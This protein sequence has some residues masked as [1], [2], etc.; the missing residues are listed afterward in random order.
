MHVAPGPGA[1]QEGAR[2][3]LGVSAREWVEVVKVG[4]RWGGLVASV[5]TGAFLPQPRP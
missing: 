2:P 4:A 3:Q 5:A 1:A